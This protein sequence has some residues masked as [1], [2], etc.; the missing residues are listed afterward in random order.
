MKRRSMRSR[1][2]MKFSTSFVR[3]ITKAAVVLASINVLAEDAV[4]VPHITMMVI[5]WQKNRGASIMAEQALNK[6]A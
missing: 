4:H 3:S 6:L 5:T 1:K 2:T